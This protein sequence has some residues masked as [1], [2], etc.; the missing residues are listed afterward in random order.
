MLWNAEVIFGDLKVQDIIN[1]IADL[2]KKIFGFV[3]KE[4]GWKDAE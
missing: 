1:A 4:E 3:G 2:L